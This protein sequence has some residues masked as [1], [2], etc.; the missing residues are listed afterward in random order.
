M[1]VLITALSKTQDFNHRVYLNA[2]NHF[3]DL[4]VA[5][6]SFADMYDLILPLCLS[7]QALLSVCVCVHSDAGAE[8]I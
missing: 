4:S 3:V 7:L 6:S 2:S 1:P 8:C 5:F